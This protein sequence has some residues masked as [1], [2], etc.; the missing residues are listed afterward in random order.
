MLTEC[1]VLHW[2]LCESNFDTQ[3]SYAQT[4]WAARMKRYSEEDI[5]YV[6]IMS[7]SLAM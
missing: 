4:Q 3:S 5:R 7:N 2:T 1:Y 6:F